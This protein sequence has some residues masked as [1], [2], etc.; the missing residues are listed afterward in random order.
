MEYSVVSSKSC[1]LLIRR[2]TMLDDVTFFGMG[3]QESYC[4]KHRAAS[5]GLYHAKVS[6]PERVVRNVEQL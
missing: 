6:V 4:D 3:P 2:D 1:A 5:H